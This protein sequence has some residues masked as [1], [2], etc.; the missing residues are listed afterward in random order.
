MKGSWN[1]RSI[2]HI[3]LPFLLFF[4]YNF[5]AVFTAPARHLCH[6]VQRDALLTFKNEFEIKKPCLD[7]IRPKTESW[8]INSDCCDWD[9]I[10][11]DTKSWEVIELD[12]S[13]SCLHGRLHSNS[14]LYKVK[15]LTTLDLSYNYFS[16]H[17]SPSIGNF[18]HL[19]TL[20]L[21]KNYFSGWIP[22][23]VGNLS[24]LTI[25]DLSGNDFIGELPSFG[26]M[27]QMNLLSVEFNKLS[28]NFP[29]SL[30]NLEMLSDLYLSHNQ[31]TGT[32]PSNMSSLYNLEYFEAWDNS[33]SG[34][35]SSSL[36]TIPSLTYVDLRDNQLK[37][38]L[39]F[40]N[41]S[42]PSKLTSLVLGNNNF[43]GP[44]PKSVSK[45][46]N[47]QDLDL[48]RL[49]TQGPVDFS[50]FSNLKLLQLL[51]ISHLNT[52]TTVDLNAILHSNLKSIFL[53]DLSGNHVSTTN[54]SSGVNHHLQM[55]S[56]LYLSG[57][58]ITEFPELLRTQKKLT[59]LDISNN[60]IKGH[61]PG[62][63]WTLPTLNFVDLSYN[64]FI[65]FER[66]TKLGL[67]MQYL[68][69]SNN[70]FTGEIPSFICD[71][72][73]LIT[74]DL[75]S[76]NLNGVIPHCMGNLKSNIS[77]LNL[78]QNHLSGDLPNNTFASLRSLDVG[79]NQLTGKLPRSLIHFSTL[80]VLNVESN[81]IS[82]TFPV[83]LSS[84][85]H[86]QVLV[87]R[88]N[89]FHGPVHQASFPTLRIIDVSDNHF[90]GTLPSNYF[91]NWSAMSSLKANEDRSKEKYMGDSF[92]YYH[93]SMVLTNKGI[94]MELVRILKIYTALDFSGNKL[95]GEIPRSIGALKELHV[96]NLSYNAFTHHIPSSM[97]NLTALESLDVSQNK[98]SGEIPQELGSLSYL[99]YM[100]F[101]HNQLVG[102]VPGGTQFRRQKCSSFEENS[103]LF[104]PALDEVCR[105]IH[106]PAPQQHEKS[107]PEE[108]KEEV[109]SWVAAAIGF[110]P[111]VVFGL[112]IGYILFSCKQEWFMNVFGRNE[113]R[114]STMLKAKSR[115]KTQAARRGQ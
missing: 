105:D 51:N 9:G 27:N 115:F 10:T 79:H 72:R 73:S 52:P 32:L 88:S 34:T 49:N 96:L 12:L 99:S 56:Q 16:G 39:E 30:L 90:N 82:D 65:G 35:L 74:L 91:V 100:N 8:A 55:I 108:E 76:N 83:W 78:R 114:S 93:D 19:T 66:S 85:K 22:S 110:G 13:R 87:L 18:S 95:E 3:T 4:I 103:G 86:L 48:S 53:L 84:L 71:M 92:G 67:S 43:I 58:G 33:F 42:S 46:V 64:M 62:W 98:L 47:L 111:G 106:A 11:C 54:K 57:C 59:N 7:G 104:G 28:G 63:L 26:S 23:S 89:E 101:S 77:F 75:S 107:K 68:V 37:G 41:I 61:V 25:L 80:E 29:H 112:T 97:G 94:E 31:F 6:P 17:I 20:D 102:L 60:K 44:I 50:V 109:V 14:S 21:S 40:G 15:N 69:G 81:R 36:F 5:T 113:R 1:S 38:T 70:N 24:H 45:L 2:I